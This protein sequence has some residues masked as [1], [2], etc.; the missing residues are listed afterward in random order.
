MIIINLKDYSASSLVMKINV[1][2]QLRGVI[3]RALEGTA[4]LNKSFRKF[5]CETMIL[6][7]T[8]FG[9]VNYTA[10]ARYSDTCESTFRQNFKKEFDWLAFNRQFV[11]GTGSRRTAIAIDP[12]YIDKSG[13]KIPGLGYFWSGCAQKVKWGLE[14][15]GIAFINAD[16][17]DAVHLRAVQ[18]F[19]GRKRRGRKPAFMKFL[20]KDDGL[21]C[22]YLEAIFKY[23][24][25]LLKLSGMVVADAFFA[26]G[27]F[28]KGLRAIGFHLI[29]RLHDNGK[30]RYLYTGEQKGGRGRPKKYDGYVDLDN[31][32]PGVFS[33]MVIPDGNGE[34]VVLH[35]GNVWVDCLGMECKVVVADYTEPGKKTQT[36]KVY[37]CTD[38]TMEGKD[39]F[40]LYRTRF[41]IEFLYRSGKGLTGLTHCQARNEEAQDFA[42]NM[43]LSSINVMREFASL[44][45]YER[46]SDNSIKL[47]MHNAF[48]LEQFISI[49]G[50]SPK[51]GIN[52][53]DFKELLFH[54]V[55]DAG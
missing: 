18:T 10:M 49:S 29:S 21:V 8:M 50:F 25:E 11:R 45:G 1:L 54:G 39:I 43:S 4:K 12:S 46:L 22:K 5:F 31:L 7:I 28:V 33:L 52:D 42:F 37:F 14:I 6:Y 53:T 51:R 48:M 27:P 55:R 44:Y 23:R 30:M 24:K 38:T 17:A 15:L 47:L 13:K 40:D 3:E 20:K 32:R 19:K 26:N 34:S 2:I 35:I 16:L 36:R 41:Q 9:R